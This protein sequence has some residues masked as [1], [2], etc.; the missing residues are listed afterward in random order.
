MDADLLTALKALSDASR[1][2]I[3]RL[4]AE[5]PMVVTE[6]ARALGLTPATAVHHLARL[7]EAGLVDSRE[8]RPYVEYALVEGRLAEIARQL[9]TTGRVGTAEPA[10]PPRPDG[11]LRPALLPGPDGVLRPAP[12]ATILRDCLRDGR[13]VRMPVD[14]EARLVLLRYLADAVLEPGVRYPKRK[15]NARLATVVDDPRTLRH[16]LVAVGIL[17]RDAGAYRLTA[18]RSWPGAPERRPGADGLA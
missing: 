9:E 14:A 2:R 11:V 18:R 16:A 5:R 3:I 13:V 8:R 4:L 12:E 17:A 10:L 7:R 6:L 15:V 1:L